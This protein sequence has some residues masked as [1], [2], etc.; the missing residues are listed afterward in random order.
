MSKFDRPQEFDVVLGHQTIADPGSM[1]LG[2]IEKIIDRLD[3][4]SIQLKILALKD[5]VHYGKAGLLLV[6]EH[7]EH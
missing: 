4:D 1:V 5:A 7:L 3:T 2:G 6:L